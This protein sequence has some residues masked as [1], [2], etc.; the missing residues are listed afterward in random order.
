VIWAIGISM[1]LL[2]LLIRLPFALLFA[3]GLLI[4]L[5]HNSLDFY[6]ATHEGNYPYL[7]TLIH[8]QG[9]IPIAEGHIIQVIYPFL[10]WTGVMILGYCFGK[11]YLQDIMNRNKRALLMGAGLV[12][13]FIMLRAIN[14]YGDPLFWSEQKNFTYTILSFLNPQKYP[15]SLIYLCM[16]IGPALIVLGTLG[17]INN[18]FTRFVSVFGKVPLFYYIIHFYVL[19]LAAAILFLYRGHAFEEGM[20]GPP[21]FPFK[22]VAIGEGYSLAIVYLVWLVLIL[23]LYPLCRWYANYKMRNRS[24]WVSYL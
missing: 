12:A 13:M 20:A 6:E 18:K 19:H 16:T 2:G 4:V 23:A 24:W 10:P 1:F 15:P 14:V 8:R 22:F 7:Y 17:E 9:G 5:G 11:F 21:G 3:I